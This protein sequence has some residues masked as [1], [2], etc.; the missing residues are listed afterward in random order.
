MGP[1]D[2][3]LPEFRADVADCGRRVKPAAPWLPVWAPCGRYVA[4]SGAFPR[5]RRRV[6]IALDPAAWHKGILLT[7]HFGHRIMPASYRIVPQLNLYLVEFRGDI[8]VEQNMEVYQAYR[9]DPLYDG[10]Q[11]LLLDTEGSRFPDNFFIETQRIA[12]RMAPYSVARDPRARTSIYAPEK[13]P[14]GICRL[15]RDAVRAKIDYEIE[16]FRDPVAALE[17]LDLDTRDPAVR[18]LLLTGRTGYGAL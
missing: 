18:S 6:N 3:T 4:R 12:M 9:A 17:F 15:Y 16:V 10:G 8:T 2:S 13:V 7:R 11:H 5:G 14:Y 1:E